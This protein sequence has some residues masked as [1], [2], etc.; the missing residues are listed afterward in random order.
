MSQTPAPPPALFATQPKAFPGNGAL[1]SPDGRFVLVNIDPENADPILG[2]AHAIYLLDLKAG[3]T[4][5]L[6][7]Y[8]RHIDACFSPDGTHLLLTDWLNSDGAEVRLY[9]L[10]ANAERIS[11]ERWIAPLKR[12]SPQRRHAQRRYLQAL[13]WEDAR[14]FRLLW[15]GYGPEGRG[16]DFRTGLVLHLDGRS[17]EVF[18][19]APES[20][21][22]R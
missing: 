2:E 5:R 10:G 7:V 15:W 9:H 14:T 21:T 19:A 8:A 16:G 1:R 3:A 20:M 4:R 18:P 17:E 22:G 6:L 11:L 12:Q 13:G